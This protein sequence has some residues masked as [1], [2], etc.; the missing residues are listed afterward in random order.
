MTGG[1]ASLCPHGLAIAVLARN[2]AQDEASQTVAH[3]RRPVSRQRAPGGKAIW[4]EAFCGYPATPPPGA[5]ICRIKLQ[6]A[7]PRRMVHAMSASG[8]SGLKLAVLRSAV[9]QL[10]GLESG[11][12]R[13]VGVAIA[14]GRRHSPAR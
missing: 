10:V 2:A 13:S 7:A 14:A 8:R 11:A 12:P 4:L 3:V 5:L 1:F 6:E 9:F